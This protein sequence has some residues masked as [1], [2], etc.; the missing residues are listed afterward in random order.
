MNHII[1]TLAKICQE[2]HLKW[3]QALSI[4]LFWIRVVPRSVLKLSPYETVYGRPLQISVL[5]IPDL[6]LEHEW[7]IKQYVQHLGQTLI[8]LHKFAHC[9][10]AYLSIK[11][12]H[13]FQM[14]EDLRYLNRS[15]LEDSST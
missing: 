12:L 10:S 2:M 5:G 14:G 4:A 15:T 7:K 11:P 13:L 9:R 1:K 3:D 6:D 8:F